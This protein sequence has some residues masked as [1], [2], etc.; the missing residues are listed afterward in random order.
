V[1]FG[2]GGSSSTTEASVSPEQRQMF[3]LGND[4]IHSGGLLGNSDYYKTQGFSRM[5]PWRS[6]VR[7]QA[8]SAASQ[9]APQFDAKQWQQMS[10]AAAQQNPLM[11]Q[12]PGITRD[13]MGMATGYA[14]PG[15][16][17]GLAQQTAA[18]GG[19][20]A[21][22]QYQ[23]TPMDSMAFNPDRQLQAAQD[24][25]TRIASPQIL[26]NMVASG[27][28]ANSGAAIEAQQNAM[29]QL[30]MPILQRV[31]QNQA[32]WYQPQL[33][34]AV[35]GG[36]NQQGAQNQ[37]ISQG[38]GGQIQGGLAQQN[39]QNQMLGTGLQGVLQGLG[40]QQQNVFQQAMNAP[41]ALNQLLTGQQPA[42]GNMFNLADLSRQ[43]E[44]QEFMR[45]QQLAQSVT[46][47]G[48][49]VPLGGGVQTTTTNAS[50]NWLGALGGAGTG[51]AMGLAA[52]PFGA[53]AGGVGGLLTGFC[54]VA[55]ALYGEGSREAE[56]ARIWV[57]RGWQGED[58]DSFRDWYL[59][60]GKIVA[61]RLHNDP[62]YRAQAEP[63]LRAAFDEFVAEG[64]AWAKS[65]LAEETAEAE[66]SA[67]KSRAPK[68]DKKKVSVKRD[69]R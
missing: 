19:P 5:G 6:D 59:E 40:Q 31:S 41:A 12:S 69:A 38:F 67:A 14:G 64:R 58:A 35:Q 56:L 44:Q 32:N 52:G 45:R 51:A 26:Q 8:Y 53:L 4:L 2:G 48:M 55:D 63:L 10:Q 30:A 49:G 43:M 11:Q 54:W 25:M 62:E 21:G 20:G 23:V 16:A 60:H 18:Y 57:S 50:P 61:E 34:G 13:A 37:L 46:G 24:Y 7:N 9:M 29:A 36:L 15:A 1:G 47:L 17:Q 42:Y 3:Q 66:E 27:S 22:G 39:A 28:G 33:Q 68:P 65:L